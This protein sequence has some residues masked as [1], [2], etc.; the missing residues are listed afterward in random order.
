MNVNVKTSKRYFFR[1]KF[2]LYLLESGT[3]AAS[4][5]ITEWHTRYDVL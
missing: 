1:Y 5:D 4:R 2:W 3:V